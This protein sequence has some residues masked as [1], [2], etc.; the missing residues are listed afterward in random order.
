MVKHK[1]YTSLF[2]D[3]AADPLG[4]EKAKELILQYDND[5]RTQPSAPAINDLMLAVV[6]SFKD[7]AIGG[8]ATFTMERGEPMLEI[9]T[10]I[11]R[12]GRTPENVGSRLLGEIFAYPSTPEVL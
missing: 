5:F 10:G 3:P 9:L 12:Y 6:E 7:E 4:S 1:N 2:S 8:L 11:R